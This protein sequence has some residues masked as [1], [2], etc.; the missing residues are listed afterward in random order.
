MTEATVASD[1]EAVQPVDAAECADG[2]E[3][4]HAAYQGLEAVYDGQDAISDLLRDADGDVPEPAADRHEALV[5]ATDAVGKATCLRTGKKRRDG[6]P[7]GQLLVPEPKTDAER[8]ILLW[9]ERF[10]V[11]A[12]RTS[13]MRQIAREIGSSGLDVTVW[14]QRIQGTTI[15]GYTVVVVP[16]VQDKRV[17]QLVPK[18]ISRPGYVDEMLSQLPVN[19]RKS[20]QESASLE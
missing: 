15:L 7:I 17:Y 2:V 19:G 13:S 4:L 12:V 3:D 9:W 20:A 6:S 8:F 10:T 16:V 5:V 1:R 14:M 11:H 18:E